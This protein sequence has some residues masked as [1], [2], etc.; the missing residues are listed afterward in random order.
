MGAATMTTWGITSSTPPPPHTHS[1]PLPSHKLKRQALLR[2][3]QQSKLKSKSK[4]K[5]VGIPGGAKGKKAAPMPFALKQAIKVSKLGF[6]GGCGLR[7]LGGW[8]DGAGG[9]GG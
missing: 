6:V 5:V 9:G 3:R 7:W 4:A 2:G 1:S 8:V